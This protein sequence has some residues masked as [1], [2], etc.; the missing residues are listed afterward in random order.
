MLTKIVA[1]KSFSAWSIQV[2][3][4][5]GSLFVLRVE[6]T[7][8]LMYDGALEPALLAP[9]LP[10]SERAFGSHLFLSTSAM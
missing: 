4:R 8:A 3:T 10:L 9:E 1:L 2:F 7:I 5:I 6:L